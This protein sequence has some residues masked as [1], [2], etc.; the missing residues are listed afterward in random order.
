[1]RRRLNPFQIEP[2]DPV[3]VIEDRR[4]LPNHP[5]NL[6]LTKAQP[7]QPRNVQHLFPVNH[8]RILGGVFGRAGT[9]VCPRPLPQPGP[10]NRIR[11]AEPVAHDRRLLGVPVQTL[12]DGHRNFLGRNAAFDR[13]DHELGRMELLLP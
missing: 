11:E 3:N 9:V 12:D 7:R 1:M 2:P 4:Q 13:L 8:R 6:I 5:L 10:N